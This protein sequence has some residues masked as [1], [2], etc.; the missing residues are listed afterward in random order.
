MVGTDEKNWQVFNEVN[1]Y[2][3]KIDLF[4]RHASI[5]RIPQYCLYYLEHVMDSQPKIEPETSRESC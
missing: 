1:Y 4:I 3:N 5:Y 2:I